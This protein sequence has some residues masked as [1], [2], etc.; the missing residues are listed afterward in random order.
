M[1]E[2]QLLRTKQDRLRELPSIGTLLEQEVVQAWIAATSRSLVVGALQQT[3][4]QLRGRILAGDVPDTD[5]ETVL[6]QAEAILTEHST[7]SLRRVINATGIVLHTGLGRAPLAQEAI[8]AIL[9]TASGY[10][11]LELDLTTGQRGRRTDHVAGLLA[12]ILGAEAATVVNNN[13]AATYLILHVLAAGREVIVSRGELVEIGG[14]FRL[15][16]I[17]AASG[18]VLR[19]VGTTNRTRISDYAAAVTPL[20]TALL[21]KVHAS[22]YRIVGF[23]ESATIDQIARLAHEH[24]LI[25]VD[26]LGSGAVFDFAAAGLPPEPNAQASLAAGADLVCF[27]GDKLLG[28]PQAGIISGKRELIAQLERSPL[29][30][31]LRVD[32][33]TLASLEATV[34][35]YTDPQHAIERVPVLSMLA[36]TTDILASKAERLRKLLSDALPDESFMVCSD[37]SFAGGGSLPTEELPTVVVQWRPSQRSAEATAAGLRT[38]ETPVVARVRDDS[39]C[40]DLRTI[41]A[42]DFEGLVGA[43]AEAAGVDTADDL[44]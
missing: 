3:V 2:P 36:A 5:I 26:D 28:G 11:N 37:V 10:S 39:I 19:E 33:L 18:A 27:S 35:L 17:M 12:K 41:C 6:G 21:M 29:A 25:C 43:A 34:R 4:D 40:F 30:R 23:T 7:P 13:A 9:E 22:N 20:Q 14:S 8:D 32:K 16:E 1:S 44:T 38:A 31:A 15:P 42:D 24:G